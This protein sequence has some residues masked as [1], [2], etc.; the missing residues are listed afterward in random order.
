MILI[1]SFISAKRF[2]EACYQF[3]QTIKENC[4]KLD[5]NIRDTSKIDAPF[6]ELK[7]T[8]DHIK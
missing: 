1:L 4:Q 2:Y 6:Y 3:S 5:E 7:D 8:F